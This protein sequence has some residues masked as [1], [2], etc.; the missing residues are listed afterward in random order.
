MK[1]RLCGCNVNQCKGFLKRVNEKGIE[2]IWECRPS[3]TTILSNDQAVIA[4][5]EDDEE[6][7][8]L[9]LNTNK[10]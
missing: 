6:P 8:P 5:L 10:E 9:V 1:C 4:A 3:C 2:G 7:S